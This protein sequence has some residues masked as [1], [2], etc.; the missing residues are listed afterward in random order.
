MPGA[1]NARLRPR[2]LGAFFITAPA[3]AAVIKKHGMGAELTASLEHDP[4]KW[5]PVFSEKKIMLPTI[6]LEADDDFEEKVNP[7]LGPAV[8]AGA[9]PPNRI[10]FPARGAPSATGFL[11]CRYQ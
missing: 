9:A 1:G 8:R 7:A 6:R 4:E 5:I 10:P 2:P 11:A 3:A